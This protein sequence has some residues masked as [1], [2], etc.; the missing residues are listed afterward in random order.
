MN[1]MVLALALRTHGS[2]VLSAI[3]LLM[4]KAKASLIAGVIDKDVATARDAAYK[5][6]QCHSE[7]H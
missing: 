5:V 7:K 4:R 1:C 3:H 2:R 6:A